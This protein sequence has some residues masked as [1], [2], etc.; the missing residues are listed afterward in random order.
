MVLAVAAA[1]RNVLVEEQRSANELRASTAFA[2]AEAGLEWTLARI[3]DP[4]PVG[5]DCLPSADAAARPLRERMVSIGVP[6]GNVA[7]RLW[8]DA[9]S[10][11]AMQVACVRD[12]AG[13][14]CSCPTS[15]RPDLPAV[16]IAAIAP[17]FVVELAASTR[18]DVVRVLATGCTRAGGATICAASADVAR[19]ATLRLEAAWAL[20]P[21]LRALP[22]AALTVRGDVDA[23]AA[24]LGVHNR[25]GASGGLA[26]HAGGR[27][28]APALRL[29]APAGAPPSG[30]LA[31]NDAD[32]RALP[33]ERFFA[34][35]FGMGAAAWA[36]RPGMRRVVCS[37][38]C[39]AEIAA[40]IA[41]GARLLA[42]EGD[43]TIAGPVAIGSVDEPVAVVA[44]GSLHVSGDVV[45]HGIVHAAA[46]EWNDAMPGRALVR[47]AALVGG[48]YRG[49]GAVDFERDEAVLAR[50]AATSGSFVRV[51]G[52][53]KDF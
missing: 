39:T 45:V 22:A 11:A 4:A 5:S 48:D 6:A 27:V 15:G 37:R 9:G 1:H 33:A 36:A 10:P 13:W 51:N 42:I 28:A 14:R 46:L 24:S 52:S 23:G 53:W 12:M 32:L 26:L 30:S 38:D 25:N 3:N 8:D 47:G 49:S 19:E 44:T 21:A 18:G 50:L 16:G 29:G 40:A 17:A 34:R 7:P 2:A 31:S 41:A 20:L 35:T 43:A